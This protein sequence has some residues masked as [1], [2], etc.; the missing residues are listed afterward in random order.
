MFHETLFLN[1]CK[2]IYFTF[3]A[4]FIAKRYSIFLKRY[5]IFVKL[6]IFGQTT[7][8]VELTEFPFKKIRGLFMYLFKSL[9]SNIKLIKVQFIAMIKFF[10]I[11][12]LNRLGCILYP[13][14]FGLLNMYSTKQC[15]RQVRKVKFEKW[16]R[17]IVL[18]N[19]VILTP[20]IRASHYFLFRMITLVNGSVQWEEEKLGC[21]KRIQRYVTGTFIHT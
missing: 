21:Q 11:N 17:D 2:L 10:S 20:M 18:L 15:L 12:W 4:V 14:Y 8:R 16:H 7:V 5:G 3:S 19:H 13:L 6:S 9:L 1:Q